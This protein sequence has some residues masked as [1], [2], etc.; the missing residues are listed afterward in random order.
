MDNILI[1]FIMDTFYR[2]Y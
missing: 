2:R 1:I